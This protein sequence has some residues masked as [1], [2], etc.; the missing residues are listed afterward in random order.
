MRGMWPIVAA[1]LLGGPASAQSIAV[2]PLVD[3]RLRWEQVKQDGA[4]ATADA[5]TARIRS[6]LSAQAG[7][8]QALVE[9]EATLAIV[10]RYDSGTNGLIRFP[11]VVDPQNVE[12]NRAQLRYR[13]GAVTATAGRQVIE[14][15]DQRFVGSA[16]FRQNQQTFDAARVQLGDAKKVF[17]DLTYAWSDRTV[18]GIDGRGGRPQAIG[19]DSLFALVGAGLPVGTLTGFAYLV[20]EDAAA[21]Q[22]YR[23]SS[24]T[25][26]VRLAGTRPV[27][28][29]SVAYAASWARQR[30]WHRNPN[31]YAATYWLAEAG[32][33]AKRWALT[34]GHEVLGA[35]DGRPLTSVQTPLAALFKF[36]GWADKFTTTPPNGIRDLY[37][38]AALNWRKL[39]PANAASVSATFH[40]FR[41]DRLDQH[42]GSEWD[43]LASVR[44]G[45]TSLSARY[46]RY[47]ADTFATDTDK[48]WLEA[49][50]AL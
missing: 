40:R 9:A 16:S 32:I 5:V 35:D 12:L 29:V 17:A 34:A 37:G 24:Q 39:G 33:V 30:D 47:R 31:R 45:Q 2:K 13:R 49:D 7:D 15:A 20:D 8:L 26:G 43:L 6:G 1:V 50:W 11:L 27:G 36:Q 42:Y 38:T 41:S 14:L 46:A 23:L 18:N 4:P 22:G 3:A 21:V 25:Y 28:P 19:G 44:R 48:F 10:E